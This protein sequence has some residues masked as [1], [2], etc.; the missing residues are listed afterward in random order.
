MVEKTFYFVRSEEI[1]RQRFSLPDKPLDFQV[2]LR[3]Y[4][5]VEKVPSLRR[6]GIKRGIREGKQQKIMLRNFLCM[7]G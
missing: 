7:I 3:S 2:A 6:G 4:I 1:K 5:I